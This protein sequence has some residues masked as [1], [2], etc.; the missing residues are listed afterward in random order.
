MKN[1]SQPGPIRPASGGIIPPR[2]ILP[3]HR[4]N[5]YTLVELMIATSIFGLV[6]AGTFGVYLMCNKIWRSTALNMQ[7]VRESSLAL[8]RIV[9]GLET[10]GGLRTASMV[11]LNTNF[12]GEWDS[13]K[14]W[15]TG[16]KPPAATSSVHYLASGSPDGS[17][18]LVFSNAF[19]NTRWID[20]NSKQRNMVLWTD[21]SSI[22][23][24][25]SLCN[26][27][28]SAGVTTNF[29]GSVGLRVTVLRSD[30]MFNAS[31]TVSTL[32]KIRNK[33]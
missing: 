32:I 4:R 8:S 15:E 26:Y 21:T 23:K 10:D 19:V 30:G 28:A 9:Y 17:W 29:N 1:A 20:Y 14:Y 25:Q 11:A 3:C 16:A 27:V 12:H 24:R 33:P 31:N 5:G 6:M 18:R 13:I 22:A 2:G 7:A